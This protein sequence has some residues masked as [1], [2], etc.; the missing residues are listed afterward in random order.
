MCERCKRPILLSRR[1]IIAAGAA[2]PAPGVSVA[3]GWGAFDPD[4]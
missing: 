3:E 1:R 4:A 2:A